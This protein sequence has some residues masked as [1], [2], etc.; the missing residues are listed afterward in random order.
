VL[1]LIGG[2][3]SV[4]KTP[5]ACQLGARRPADVVSVDA[6]PRD[7]SV[8]RDRR[9]G[10]PGIWEHPPGELLV[11][12]RE[13]TSTLGP[14]RPLLPHDDLADRRALDTV[15]VVVSLDDV[16]RVAMDLPEVTEGERHG[17]RTW[18]AAGKAFAWERPFSKADIRRFG[19]VKPPD[20]PIIAV[21]VAD[22]GE[23]EAVL[24]ESARGVFTISHFDGYAA[25]LIQLR[26]VGKRVL[27]ELIID[28]WVACAPD[29][30]ADEYLARRRGR[31]G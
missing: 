22:L 19:D 15:V 23:K 4:G 16:A 2:S 29:R 27:R 13:G 11:L 24:A 3:S 14:A 6:R 8:G 20:G 21:S 25:I 5:A 1:L 31:P 17:N 30:L 9:L 28:G 18:F 12:L 10:E 26:I 7:R